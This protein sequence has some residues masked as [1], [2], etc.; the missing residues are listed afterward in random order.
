[1]DTMLHFDDNAKDVNLG[2]RVKAIRK[3]MCEVVRRPGATFLN[4][5]GCIN[6]SIP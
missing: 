6:S 3:T 4:S 5:S 1:M 2:T